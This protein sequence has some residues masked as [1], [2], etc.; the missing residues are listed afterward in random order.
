MRHLKEKRIQVCRRKAITEIPIGSVSSTA[1]PDE[2]VKAVVKRL[3]AL[4][5]CRPRKVKT[6]ANTI[7]AL[8]LKT[9]DGDELSALIAELKRRKLIAVDGE[10]I[11]YHL[12]G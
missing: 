1:S 9:L 2:R 5:Q 10:K 12:S 3:T 8:F 6:L 11:S 7:N 4:G